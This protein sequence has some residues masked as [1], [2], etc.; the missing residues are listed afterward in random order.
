MLRHAV[1]CIRLAVCGVLA[2]SVCCSLSVVWCVLL[3]EPCFCFRLLA[4]DRGAA[5]VI[6]D[7][8]DAA[9]IVVAAVEQAASITPIGYSHLLRKRGTAV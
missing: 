6:A 1:P 7:D 2:V 3:S 8:A 9:V 4:R 5:V